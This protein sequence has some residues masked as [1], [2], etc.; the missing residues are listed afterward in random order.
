MKKGVMLDGRG[1]KQIQSKIRC[2]LVLTSE[3][4]KNSSDGHVVE[5]ISTFS[6][7]VSQILSNPGNVTEIV[8]NTEQKEGK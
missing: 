7:P 4:D 2:L 6:A 3:F 8:L 1:K 5:V